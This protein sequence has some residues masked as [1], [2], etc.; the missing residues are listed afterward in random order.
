MGSTL[1]HLNDIFSELFPCEV[2]WDCAFLFLSPLL[3]EERKSGQG[4][5]EITCSRS[6]LFITITFLA[7]CALFCQHLSH[8]SQD[9]PVG[10]YVQASRQDAMHFLYFC[11]T[12]VL[13]KSLHMALQASCTCAAATCSWQLCC[14]EI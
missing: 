6:L 12:A 11:L 2:L 14:P 5:V 4:A 8:W 10:E 7:S 9:V 3:S 13:G 1:Y